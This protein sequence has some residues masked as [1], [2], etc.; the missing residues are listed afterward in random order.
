ME[1]LDF[2]A[3]SD[4]FWNVANGLLQGGAFVAPIAIVYIGGA[5]VIVAIACLLSRLTGKH[6]GKNANQG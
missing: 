4:T 1:K 2:D 5:V 3:A 6:G